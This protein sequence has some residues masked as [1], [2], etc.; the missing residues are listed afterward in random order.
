MKG[1]GAVVLPI[2]GLFVVLVGLLAAAAPARHALRIHPTE[3][4]RQE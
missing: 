4:L 2:V 1:S 3:A